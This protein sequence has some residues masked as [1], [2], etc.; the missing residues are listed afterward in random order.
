M[1]ETDIATQAVDSVGVNQATVLAIIGIVLA[2]ILVRFL[3]RFSTRDEK[4]S[5]AGSTEARNT[6][7]EYY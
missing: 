4:Y 1:T 5:F 6:V 3:T 7:L 2:G